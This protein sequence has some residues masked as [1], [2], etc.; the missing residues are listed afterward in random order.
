[1]SVKYLVCDSDYWSQCHSRHKDFQCALA[2]LRK[3]TGKGKTVILRK[4]VN[5]IYV[6]LTRDEQT[7]ACYVIRKAKPAVKD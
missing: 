3:L 7:F 6:P 5:K 2:S 4:T 1:M